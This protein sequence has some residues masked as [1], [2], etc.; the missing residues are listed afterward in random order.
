MILCRA[1]Y[2]LD[3]VR[4]ASRISRTVSSAHRMHAPRGWA[5]GPINFLHVDPDGT[6]WA[7]T[8]GGLSRVKNGRVAT[9]ASKNGL[10]CDAVHWMM[11][12]DA[13]SVWLYTTCGLVRIARPEL[14]AGAADPNADD[15]GHGFRQFRRSQEPFVRDRLQPAGRQGRGWQDCGSCPSATSASSILVTFLSTQLPP[16]VHIEQVTADRKTYWPNLSGDAPSST[17]DCR[18]SFAI[19]DRVTRR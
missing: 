17:R 9:L 7:A 14:D 16:P 1:V 3:F 2:G 19:S 11:E 8:D 18:R 6:L 5:T 4:A 15:P 12:D 10:P 13:H